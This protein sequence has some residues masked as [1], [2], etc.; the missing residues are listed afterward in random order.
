[1]PRLVSGGGLSLLILASLLVFGFFSPV[2]SRSFYAAIA[3]AA[4][5]SANSNAPPAALDTNH[6]AKWS[7][8]MAMPKIS[9]IVSNVYAT[10]GTK[11]SATSNHPQADTPHRRLAQLQSLLQISL[12]GVSNSPPKEETVTDADTESINPC[13]QYD[14]SIST[15]RVAAPESTARWLLS[16]VYPSQSQSSIAYGA[17]AP[18]PPHRKNDS[19]SAPSFVQRIIPFPSVYRSKASSLPASSDNDDTPVAHRKSNDKKTGG[20]FRS[21]QHKKELTPK[22]S[23]TQSKIPMKPQPQP[24]LQPAQAVQAPRIMSSYATNDDDNDSPA[25]PYSSELQPF[26]SQQQISRQQIIMQPQ[27]EQEQQ[28]QSQSQSQQPS[29]RAQDHSADQPAS[30][31]SSAIL[32]IIHNDPPPGKGISLRE[33]EIGGSC[34]GLV[35]SVVFA[36]ILF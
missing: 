22:P 2:F 6:H 9:P 33:K 10:L 19:S 32:S 34:L 23:S 30:S 7:L 1:M 16:L 11:L 12:R 4:V 20:N 8:A 36:I 29:I 3:P 18:A 21:A 24:Q 31:I 27:Q 13:V 26:F 35:I 25:A 17:A 28:N 14:P 5:D 15:D